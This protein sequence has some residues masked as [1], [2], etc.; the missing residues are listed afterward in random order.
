MIPSPVIASEAKQSIGR[1][2]KL[3]CFVAYAPRNDEKGYRDAKLVMPGLVPGIHV[4]DER[5]RKKDVDGRD[6]PCHDEKANRF[7]AAG[8]QFGGVAWQR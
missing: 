8:M 4:L 1:R 7:L 6:K 5:C 2:T 3:D